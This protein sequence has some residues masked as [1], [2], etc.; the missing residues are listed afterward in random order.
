MTLAREGVAYLFQGCN[1]I[2]VAPEIGEEVARSRLEEAWEDD[3]ALRLLLIALDVEEDSDLRIEAADCVEDMLQN[4]NALRFIED[5]L[6][7]QALP[8]EADPHFLMEHQW[9]RIAD[10]LRRVVE[11]Q[12]FIILHRQSWN[13]LPA[14]LFEEGKADFEE[15]AIAKGAFRILASLDP[16]T[17]DPNIAI[18]ACH[19]ALRS[20]PNAREIVSRWTKNF[21]RQGSKPIIVPDDPEETNIAP[22]V[23]PPSSPYKEYQ[24]ALQQ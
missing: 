15:K 4:A 20:L 18:L 11:K 2:V 14:E 3:R 17:K 22:H 12:P 7:S 9:P 8:E 5:Q 19:A 13:I 21:K 24:S 23:V 16:A 10:L 6:Y 1:D